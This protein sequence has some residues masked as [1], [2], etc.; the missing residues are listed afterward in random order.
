MVEPIND[1]SRKKMF[2][3]FLIQL[4]ELTTES[5]SKVE[6]DRNSR[7]SACVCVCVVGRLHKTRETN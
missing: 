7:S 4:I 5:L 1:T 6:I 2:K 3:Q